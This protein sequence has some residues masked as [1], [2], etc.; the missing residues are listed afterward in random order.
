MA[1]TFG[2]VQEFVAAARR[3]GDFWYASTLLAGVAHDIAAKVDEGGGELLFP[4]AAADGGESVA[5]NKVVAS[6]LTK[7]PKEFA[8]RVID[9][10]REAL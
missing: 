5:S 8:D 1:F 6:V 2:P 7:N 10:T 3:T 4:V 9:S